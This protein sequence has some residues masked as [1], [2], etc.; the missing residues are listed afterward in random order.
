MGVLD[1]VKS[2]LAEPPPQPGHPARRT[3]CFR[4]TKKPVRATLSVA[5][6]SRG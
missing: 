6:R 4:P 5:S 2:W 3:R 1:K